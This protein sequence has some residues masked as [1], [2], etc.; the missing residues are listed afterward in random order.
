MVNN[1]NNNEGVK[2]MKNTIFCEI[3]AK[4]ILT[5]LEISAKRNTKS[6][7]K[8]LLYEP[9]IPKKL[10]IGNNNSKNN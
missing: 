10:R 8:G 5:A 7:C 6:R 4:L 1:Q 3:G 2:L 9:E